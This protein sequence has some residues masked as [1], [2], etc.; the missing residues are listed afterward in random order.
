MGEV[1]PYKEDE[2]VWDITL[3]RYKKLDLPESETA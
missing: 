3:D 2:G 1:Q